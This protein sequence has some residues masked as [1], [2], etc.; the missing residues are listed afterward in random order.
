MGKE[1]LKKQIKE[2]VSQIKTNS[3][4]AHFAD[5][6]V[7]KLLSLK[8]QLDVEPTRIHI[9]EKD[10]IKEYDFGSTT[11]TK[12]KGGIIFH[13]KSGMDIVI[14]P[15][16]HSLYEHINVMLEMKDNY[17][18]LNEDM[19]KAYENIYT[20]TSWLLT[21]PIYATIDDNMFF[22]IATDIL[23]HFDEYIKSKE[24]VLQEETP[25]ENAEFENMNELLTKDIDKD[26]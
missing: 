24:K 22:G 6:L 23:K 11:Y 4:D 5:K 17:E 10:V 2:V 18:K 3:K 14:R 7:D 20:A 15:G 9:E 8:G 25:I 12:Y 1:K 21:S 26:A 19:K 16:L 13:A